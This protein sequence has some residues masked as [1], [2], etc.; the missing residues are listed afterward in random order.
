MSGIE[1]LS[2]TQRIIVLP[3]PSVSVINA[4]PPG[5]SPNTSNVEAIIGPR[6]GISGYAGL[7]AQALVPDILIPASIAISAY[8]WAND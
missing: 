5:P 1:V 8:A 3:N 4:G 6:N 7:D 2:R